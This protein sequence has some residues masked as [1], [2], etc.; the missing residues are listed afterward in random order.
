MCD[1]FAG[2]EGLTFIFHHRVSSILHA[3][4]LF[5]AFFCPLSD[6]IWIHGEYLLCGDLLQLQSAFC[7]VI[8]VTF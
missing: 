2:S 8:D 7:C 5:E 4:F 6:L 3:L 1:L